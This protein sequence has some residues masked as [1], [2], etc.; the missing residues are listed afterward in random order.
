MVALLLSLAG[1]LVLVLVFVGRSDGGVNRREYVRGNLAVLRSLPV[2]P[3]ATALPG[4]SRSIPYQDSNND[5][6][7][8]PI[9]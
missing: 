5:G 4:W 7:G 8:P 6:D 9:G 2:F 1:V 3:G